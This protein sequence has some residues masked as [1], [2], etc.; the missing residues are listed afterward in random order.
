LE[1][2]AKSLEFDM[3]KYF[4]CPECGNSFDPELDEDFM[5]DGYCPNCGYEIVW[6]EDDEDIDF[7][8]EY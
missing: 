1:L 2:R 7:D 5:D 4:L 6:D 8:D 3:S